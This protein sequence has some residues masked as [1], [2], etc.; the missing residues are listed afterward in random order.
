MKPALSWKTSSIWKAAKKLIH[1]ARPIRP[2]H[3]LFA[4]GRSFEPF[5]LP[6]DSFEYPFLGTDERFTVFLMKDGA[7]G[8]GL[9]LTPLAAETLSERELAQRLETF[10]DMLSKLKNPD[11]SLQVLFDSQPDSAEPSRSTCSTASFAENIACKRYEFLSQFAKTP[12]HGIRLMK[13]RILLT[14]RVSGVHPVLETEA[15]RDTEQESSEKNFSAR[16]VALRDLLTHVKAG[17]EA[18]LFQCRALGREECLLF[19]RDSLHSLNMSHSAA[20][21]H[22]RRSTAGASLS[23]QVLYHSIQVTPFGLGLGEGTQADAW[24]VASLLD[25]PETTTYGLMAKLLV[26]KIPHRIVVNIRPVLKAGDLDSKRYLL[27]HAD[28]AYGLRQ[29]ED[30][31]ATQYRL[32]REEGLLGVSLHLLV[33]NENREVSGLQ[34]HGAMRPLLSE[35]GPLL[36]GLF[37]EETLCAPLVFAST[38]PFQNSKDICALVGREYRMLS[39]NLVALLPLYGGFQGTPNPM[40]QMISRGGERIHLNPRDSNGAS[41]LAVLG[42]SGAGKS[43]SVANM[44]V[45]FMATYPAGKVFIIDKKTSYAALAWLASEEKSNGGAQY[46]NPPHN[47]PNIFAGVLSAAKGSA[48][49]DEERLPEILNLL[50]TAM[51]LL[52]PRAELSATHSRIVSDALRLSFEEKAR[53]AESR[54]D[55]ESGTVVASAKTQV[56]LPRLS[57]VVSNLHAACDALG[58]SQ[59]HAELIAECL[60]PYV[61]GG[62]YAKFFDIPQAEDTTTA[63]PLLT[64]CDLDGVSGDPVLLVLTVQAV[65]LEILRL[66]KPNAEGAPKPPSLL[67]I[68]EVGVLSSESPALVSF[69]RDAWKTMRKFGVTCVG[70]TNEVADYTEKPGPREI[71]NVSPN[72]LILTQ[73][74]SAIAEMESRIQEAKNGLVPSLYHCELLRSLKMQ[75]G[76]FAEA[77]WM[78]ET[79]QGSYVYIPTG[80][81]YWCAASDPIDLSNLRRLAQDVA[82]QF[83]SAP[84]PTF[85]ALSLLAEGFP[86]GVRS[87]GELRELEQQERYDLLAK[88]VH[89]Q[90]E[91]HAL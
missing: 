55:A 56:S 16:L 85:L 75:K 23:S 62:P 4:Q 50:L 2:P 86:S 9:W 54:F 80:F 5:L 14:L 19:L 63:P 25:A 65:I 87:K 83:P 84:S 24:Q 57:E 35:V 42:G 20:E 81:D 69:I 59:H 6:E 44:V 29:L 76:Q 49:L 32:N 91:A 3:E 43:F 33:R 38:L 17:V 13:R 74:S 45:A 66:L 90:E 53:Q 79:T 30:I 60:S 48:V 68:E 64:L 82:H 8:V 46:F 27:K 34:D 22:H 51:S 28:D 58:F 41:H 88:V 15:L 37:I 78:G 7:L 71:W 89:D 77:F 67:I 1:E 47:F 61:G 21:R 36:S 11:A 12:H 18:A 73:N 40:V 26:L 70:V 52:S 10:A 72:K 39:R 31:T